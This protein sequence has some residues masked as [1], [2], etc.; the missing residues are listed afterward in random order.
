[1]RRN[2][3]VFAIRGGCT[4]TVLP[5]W[6]MCVVNA[7]Q[8]LGLALAHSVDTGNLAPGEARALAAHAAAPARLSA[9]CAESARAQAFK[10]ALNMNV[11]TA[12]A[13]GFDDPR[14]PAAG[15]SNIDELVAA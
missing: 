12:L 1:M 6:T 2:I 9:R 7:R 11:P 5:K 14:A 15:Y 10:H 13:I 8:E 3:G 4:M